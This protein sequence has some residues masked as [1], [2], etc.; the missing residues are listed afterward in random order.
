MGAASVIVAHGESTIGTGASQTD[1]REANGFGIRYNLGGGM[2]IGCIYNE[3]EDDKDK[4]A[5]AGAK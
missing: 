5:A 1:D 2:T 3:A 4:T